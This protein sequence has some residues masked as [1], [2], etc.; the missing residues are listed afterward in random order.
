MRAGTYLLGALRQGSEASSA[1]WRGEA[2]PDVTWTA[3]GR[4]LG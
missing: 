3:A 2:V 1:S 4:R